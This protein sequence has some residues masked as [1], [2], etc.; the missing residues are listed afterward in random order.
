MKKCTQ[1]DERA[2]YKVGKKT[3]TE[4]NTDQKCR[5]RQ[6]PAHLHTQ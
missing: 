3:T 1:F 2:G 6:L 5:R 4:K